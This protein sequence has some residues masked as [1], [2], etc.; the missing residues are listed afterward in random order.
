[1]M[2]FRSFMQ[3]TLLAV[4]F[5]MS[6][7]NADDEVIIESPEKVDTIVGN[8]ANNV[9]IYQVNPKLYTKGTTFETV[10][11]RLPQ[12]AQLGVNVLYLMPIYPEGEINSVGSPYCI[13][14]YQAVNENY[15]TEAQLKQLIDDAHNKGM[16]VIFDWVGNHTSWDNNW[17]SSH[18]EWYTHDAIG[19]IIAP[20]GTGWND[21]AD[22]N[23]DN[24]EMCS[25][26]T[27][28]MLFWINNYDIDGYRCDYADGIPTTFWAN[29]ITQLRQAHGTNVL[30]LAE[31]SDKAMYDAGFDML[32]SWKS[33]AKLQELYAGKCSLTDFYEASSAELAEGGHVRFITNHDQASEKSPL[34]YYG[35]KDGA[36]SAFVLSTMLGGAPFIYGSQEVGYAS[37]LSFFNQWAFDWNADADYTNAYQSYMKA[38]EA[39]ETLRG[40]KFETYQTQSVASFYFDSGENGLLVLVN[41]TNEA[42]T[43]KTPIAHAGTQFVNAQTGEALTL[44]S[45]TTLGAYQFLI[46]KK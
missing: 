25:A 16:R 39:T 38:Y 31:S 33:T 10:K 4:P 34:S 3:I 27:S 32:Y 21:V 18:P 11:N 44:S 22:L 24:A 6:C 30:M 43:F 20:A 1:M 35:G 45:A 15:G 46:L 8:Q 23:Y 17:L 40:G 7:G 37:A 19:N 14:N 42:I 12:I 29:A 2:N 41:P 26:M 13:S 9:V 5:L 28:A 36:L